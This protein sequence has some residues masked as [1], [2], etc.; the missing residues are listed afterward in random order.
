[1]KRLLFV[2]CL[3]AGTTALCRAAPKW[4]DAE[5]RAEMFPVQTYFVG[6][7]QENIGGDEPLAEVIERAKKNALAEMTGSIRANV[8]SVSAHRR[9][10]V[11]YET[12]DEYTRNITLT[13]DLEVVG[14]HTDYWHNKRR[15]EVY[16]IAYAERQK[17]G[18]Y[19]R[20]LMMRRLNAAEDAVD[21]A[22]QHLRAD[23][24]G[25]AFRSYGKAK[26]EFKE[27]EQAQTLAAIVTQGGM[28]LGTDGFSDLRRRL[29]SLNRELGQNFAVYIHSP[30]AAPA[31]DGVVAIIKKA[32]AEQGGAL[33]YNRDEADYLLSIGGATR[34][35]GGAGQRIVYAEAEMEAELTDQKTGKVIYSSH[36]VKKSGH[37]SFALA[38]AE[39]L[40]TAAET[41]AAD[42]AR[43]FAD[44]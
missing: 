36:S 9:S 24:K 23:S 7:V 15:D 31:Y 20:Q 30:N 21:I 14:A 39:A 4:T 27:A 34:E 28:T 5:K 37:T 17:L 12:N 10:E 25:E 16:A 40:K 26:Q 38:G 35:L 42:L 1:M 13:A 41:I 22:E 19:Y 6:F 8:R 11:N 3:S 33:T 18:A 29:A 43:Y 32:F 2:V 44:Q